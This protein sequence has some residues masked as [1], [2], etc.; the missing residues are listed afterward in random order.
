MSS[1]LRDRIVLALLDTGAEQKEVHS[2]SDGKRHAGYDDYNSPIN[3]VFPGLATVDLFLPILVYM[4]GI[5]I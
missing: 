1:V 2:C 5:L 3:S 4:F